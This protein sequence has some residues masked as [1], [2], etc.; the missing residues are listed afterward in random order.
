[1]SVRQIF[2]TNTRA[3]ILL[4]GV[5]AL[6]FGLLFAAIMSVATDANAFRRFAYPIFGVTM[7]LTV[8]NLLLRLGKQKNEQDRRHD[9]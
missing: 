1:M 2:F 9:V 3:T 4:R 7:T 5:I 6:C 8:I